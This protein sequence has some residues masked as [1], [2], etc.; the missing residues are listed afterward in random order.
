MLAPKVLGDNNES[1]DLMLGSSEAYQ[2]VTDRPPSGDKLTLPEVILSRWPRHGGSVDI[3]EAI[4]K[5]LRSSVV[6]VSPECHR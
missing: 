1:L 3:T 2:H 6:I 4:R 5:V